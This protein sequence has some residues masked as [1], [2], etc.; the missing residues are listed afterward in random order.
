[1]P[2]IAASKIAQHFAINV[3]TYDRSG[4]KLYEV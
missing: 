1:M 4:V 3:Q 2:I